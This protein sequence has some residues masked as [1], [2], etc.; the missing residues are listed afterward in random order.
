MRFADKLRSMAGGEEGASSV[1]YTV[2]AA[3]IIAICV[4]VIAIF[5]EQVL[6]A[7]NAF[8]DVFAPY[9]GLG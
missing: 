3:L 4:A 2:L 8:V 7:F 1:E 5:G 6:A 9:V